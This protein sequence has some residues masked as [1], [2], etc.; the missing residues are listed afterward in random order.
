MPQLSDSFCCPLRILVQFSPLM[1]IKST[2]YVSCDRIFEYPAQYFVLP[3]L[4]QDISASLKFFQLYC[5]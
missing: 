4:N 1:Q 3:Q 2:F 5:V